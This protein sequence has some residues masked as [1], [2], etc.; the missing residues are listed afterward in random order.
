[1]LLMVCAGYRPELPYSRCQVSGKYYAVN[2]PS[3]DCGRKIPF[4]V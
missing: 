2:G 1:M 4:S 3:G